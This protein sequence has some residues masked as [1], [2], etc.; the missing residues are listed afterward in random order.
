[1]GM[2]WLTPGMLSRRGRIAQ[3]ANS[4]TSIG[5][6]VLLETA[7]IMI[8]PIIDDTAPIVGVTPAGSCWRTSASRS[9][10]SWRLR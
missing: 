2:I 9:L 5:F 8:S 10:T 6:R 7:S 4:R 1:M 3:S